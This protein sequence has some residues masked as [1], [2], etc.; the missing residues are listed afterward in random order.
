M[1]PTPDAAGWSALLTVATDALRRVAAVTRS[2]V[3][4]TFGGGTAL[5][6]QYRHRES[7]DIDIFLPDPQWLGFFDPERSPIAEHFVTD[8]VVTGTT[9]RWALPQGR[10]DFIVAPPLTPFPA[11]SLFWAEQPIPVEAPVEIATKKLYFRRHAL[12]PRDIFDVLVV[13]RQ[14]PAA[15]QTVRT[16]WRPWIPSVLQ[17]LQRVRGSWP[18]RKTEITALPPYQD[19]LDRAP[20]M[21]AAALRHLTLTPTPRLPPSRPRL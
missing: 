15:V 4:W 20:D 1:A 6:W 8:A 9:V 7:H 5:A 10:I 2:P 21:L 17:S 18:R 11:R 13:M 14:D 19:W 16:L 3:P 12:L